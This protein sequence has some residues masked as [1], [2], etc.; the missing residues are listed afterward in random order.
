MQVA[1]SFGT[2]QSN[3]NSVSGRLLDDIAK[4]HRSHQGWLVSKDGPAKK[5]SLYPKPHRW[6]RSSFPAP[7]PVSESTPPQSPPQINTHKR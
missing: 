6:V 5:I 4:A 2:Y 1:Q 7:P 3:G